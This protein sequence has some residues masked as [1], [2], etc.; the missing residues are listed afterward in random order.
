MV[1][2]VFN[3]MGEKVA[4]LLNGVMAPGTYR[5]VFDASKLT[6]GVYFYRLTTPEGS[7]LRKM[8]LLK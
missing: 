1:L 3:L 8:M 5:E 4:T 6:S 7:R 2:E